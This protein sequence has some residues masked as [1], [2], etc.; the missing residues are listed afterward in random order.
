[1]EAQMKAFVARS[2]KRLDR[3]VKARRPHRRRIGYVLSIT[4]QDAWSGK[5]DDAKSIVRIRNDKHAGN[6]SRDGERRS[7]A[8][9]AIQNW[10]H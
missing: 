2:R 1:M 7:T 3:A 5:L 8:G 9:I 10:E 6:K 4:R